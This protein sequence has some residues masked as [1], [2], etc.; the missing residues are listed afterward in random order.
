[1]T[2]IAKESD[3]TRIVRELLA[4]ELTVWR[5]AK[6]CGVSYQTAKAWKKGW[7]NPDT[8]NTYKL[9]ALRSSVLQ[10]IGTI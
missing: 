3:G 6:E 7:W 10:K 9:M 5:I 2:V 8:S 4:L 1:M